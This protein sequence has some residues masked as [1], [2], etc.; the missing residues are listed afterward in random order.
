MDRGAGFASAHGVG[1]GVGV[2]G[3]G[4][5]GVLICISSHIRRGGEWVN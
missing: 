1:V 5:R 3:G 2:G 4:V